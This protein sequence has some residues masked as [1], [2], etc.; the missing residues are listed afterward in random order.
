[1]SIH[2]AGRVYRHF[3]DVLFAHKC[4]RLV[5]EKLT[6]FLYRLCTVGIYVSLAFQRCTQVRGRCRGLRAIGKS[7]TAVTKMDI[8][9]TPCSDD[10]MAT[11]R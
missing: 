3:D 8:L 4:I 1:V 9:S 7:V 10:V 6:V 11:I 2:T 5:R